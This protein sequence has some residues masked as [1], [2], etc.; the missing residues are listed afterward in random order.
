VTA[1]LHRFTPKMVEI[2]ERGRGGGRW[3]EDVHCKCE[4]SDERKWIEEQRDVC[5]EER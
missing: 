5:K 2:K 4:E 1:T 3:Q